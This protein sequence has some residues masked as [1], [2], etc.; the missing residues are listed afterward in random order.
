VQER[1]RYQLIVHI[2]A[3]TNFGYSP[4]VGRD[5]GQDVVATRNEERDFDWSG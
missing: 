2:S 3:S 5:P 4:T 1:D